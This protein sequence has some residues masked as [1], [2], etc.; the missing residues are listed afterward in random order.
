MN[1]V[2][3]LLDMDGVLTSWWTSAFKIHGVSAGIEEIWKDMPGHYDYTDLLAQ[4]KP[5]LS[6]IEFWAPMEYD[7]WANLEIMPDALQIVKLFEDEFGQENITLCSSPSENHGCIP[8]KRAW[9]KKHLPAYYHDT[10]NQQFG[11]KKWLNANPRAILVDDH[12]KNC[13]DFYKK[14]GH[15]VLVP[16]L[17][18]VNYRMRNEVL[19][20]MVTQLDRIEEI[21]EGK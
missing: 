16:R 13:R 18:N 14:G 4:F 10:Y 15:C 2:Q 5:G 12:D 19:R 7:F 17:W 20:T 21:I 1:A 3:I 11:S 9:I 8:G 6:D